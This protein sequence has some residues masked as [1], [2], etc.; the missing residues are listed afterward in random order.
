MTALVAASSGE[1]TTT[2]EHKTA[3]ETATNTGTT[4][5]TLGAVDTHLTTLESKVFASGA[6]KLGSH[7]HVR[8]DQSEKLATTKK[9]KYRAQKAR[10]AGTKERKHGQAITGYNMYYKKK[11]QSRDSG[12]ASEG[13]VSETT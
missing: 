3:A 7:K 10:H 9:L 5:R 8:V 2:N 4:A 11:C 1:R 12:S 13:Q 6:A